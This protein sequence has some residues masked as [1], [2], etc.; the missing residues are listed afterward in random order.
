MTH[1]EQR[2]DAKIIVLNYGRTDQ[3]LKE[4]GILE[5]TYYNRPECLLPDYVP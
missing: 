1:I 2:R 4:V 5:C 3:R